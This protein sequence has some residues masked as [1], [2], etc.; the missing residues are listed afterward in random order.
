MNFMTVAENI[1]IRREPL[2]GFGFVRHQEMRRRTKELF[3]RLDISIDPEAEVRDLSVANRQMVEIAKAVSYDSDILIMDEPT[4]ALTE[5]EV[6]HLFQII[7]TLK[8]Q[9]TGIIYITHKMNELFEIADEVS[10]FRDGQFRRRA[11]R[12]RRHARRHHQADGRTRNHPDVSQADRAD[13]RRR[14]FGAAT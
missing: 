8:A 11:C 3:D 7:R 12:R 4:S 14:A 10:V 5:K 9:G 6:A 13:R 1:W 2:N